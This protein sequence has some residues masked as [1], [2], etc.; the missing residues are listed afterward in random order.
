M[1]RDNKM[2]SGLLF[3]ITKNTMIKMLEM[4]LCMGDMMMC[5]FCFIPYMN[6]IVKLCRI[7]R[8]QFNKLYSYNSIQ[9]TGSGSCT[10]QAGF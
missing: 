10:S 8:N 6:N 4:K 3:A 9:V 7:V 5:M 1:M 2:K